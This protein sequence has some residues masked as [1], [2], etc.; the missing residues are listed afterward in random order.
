MRLRPTSQ[1]PRP[2]PALRADDVAAGLGTR[3]VGRAVR[4]LEVVGSTNDAAFEAAL[5]GAP[6]GL[7]I[8]AEEQRG[9]RGR[10]GRPWHSPRGGLWCSVLLRPVVAPDQRAFLTVL[11]GLACARAIEAVTPV[12]TRIRWP[13]DVLCAGKKLAGVL[14]EIRDGPGGEGVAALGVGCNVASVPADLPP[15]V[16]SASTCLENEAGGPV[17]RLALLR[18]LCQALDDDYDRLCRGQCEALDAEWRERSA[19]LGARVRVSAADATCE[20]RVVALG[21]TAGVTLAL[22]D[23]GTRRFRS[24]HITRLELL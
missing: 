7:V 1:A 21:A 12:R 14:V 11:G 17:D 19:V 16:A 15:Q 13:N 3:C 18:A 6:E 24:E 2:T 20:G 9:G 8:V 10:L 4:C 23:G 5:E 22:P